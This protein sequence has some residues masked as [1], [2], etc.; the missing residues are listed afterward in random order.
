MNAVIPKICDRCVAKSAVMAQ[1]ES[2]LFYIYCHDEQALAIVFHEGGRIF[3]WHVIG[4]IGVDQAKARMAEVDFDATAIL[5]MK[6]SLKN[7]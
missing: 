1:Q 5:E 7:F 6:N 3:E 2:R 4:P